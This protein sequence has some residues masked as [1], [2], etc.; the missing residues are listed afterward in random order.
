MWGETDTNWLNVAL[1]IKS[2][3]AERRNPNPMRIAVTKLPEHIKIELWHGIGEVNLRWKKEM[4]QAGSTSNSTGERRQ[5]LVRW[6]ASGL[7]ACGSLLRRYKSRR[8][9]L[10]EVKRD[11][12]CEGSVGEE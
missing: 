10:S 9:S 4:G 1:G 12:I 5:G 8:I 3:S 6:M 2:M 11:S 7:Y